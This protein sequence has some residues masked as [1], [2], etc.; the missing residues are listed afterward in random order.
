MARRRRNSLLQSLEFFRDLHPG[1][2]VADLIAFLY[3]CENEGLNIT[4]L[5]QLGRF[6]GATA[7]RRARALAGPDT[8]SPRPPSLGLVQIYEGDDDARARQ[9]FL[10]GKGREARDAVG[11]LIAEAIPVAKPAWRGD[12]MRL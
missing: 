1:L 9:L 5:A 4:E 7:S 8:P 6:T 2:V 12:D 3:I 10:T 11:A